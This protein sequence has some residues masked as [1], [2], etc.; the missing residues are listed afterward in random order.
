V[1]APNEPHDAAGLSNVTG[2]AILFAPAVLGMVHAPGRAWRPRRGDPR[3]LSFLRPVCLQRVLAVPIAER[4]KWSAD[5]ADLRR[6]L[7]RRLPGYSEAAKALL[8]LRMLSAARLA[9]PKLT[10]DTGRAEPVLDE[11]FEFI[12]TRYADPISLDDVAKALARSPSN[13]ARTVR[14]ASG[15]TV[16]YW[17]RERRMV[18]ARR[19]LVDTALSVDAI[20]SRV[21]YRDAN[22]FRRQFR[23]HHGMPPGIWRATAGAELPGTHPAQDFAA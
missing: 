23:K 17:L 14:R 3:W 8:S 1:L 21:G 9:F 16:M 19:L 18:E 2:W 7:D 20:A 4:S 12:E 11:V 13:V 22:Y 15:Q 6:E 5:V 10:G